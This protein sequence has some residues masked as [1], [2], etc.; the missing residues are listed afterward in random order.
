[1]SCLKN[2]LSF[3]PFYWQFLFVHSHSGGGGGGG[4]SLIFALLCPAV[5]FALLCFFLAATFTFDAVKQ[6]HQDST[7]LV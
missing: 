7:R 5:I 1:M 4:D 2:L 3:Y 6:S